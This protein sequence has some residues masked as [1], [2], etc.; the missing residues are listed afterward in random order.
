ME[1]HTRHEILR[2]RVVIDKK[3][4]ALE[5]FQLNQE[6]RQALDLRRVGR[7]GSLVVLGTG[8]SR[9]AARNG[10]HVRPVTVEVAADAVG[11]WCSL[12]VLAPQPVRGLRVYEPCV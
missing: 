3:L 12:P 8:V 2:V 6:R 10:P 1:Q 4:Q 11:P 9:R 7:R 5:T